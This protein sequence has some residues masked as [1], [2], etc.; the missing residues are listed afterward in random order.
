V[1]DEEECE[2]LRDV[3]SAGEREESWVVEIDNS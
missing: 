1:D 2:V 3:A